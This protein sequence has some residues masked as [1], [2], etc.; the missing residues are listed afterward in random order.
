MGQHTIMTSTCL[1]CLSLTLFTCMMWSIC[2]ARANPIIDIPGDVDL[3]EAMKNIPA[4]SESHADFADPVG[5]FLSA[6]VCTR[7]K[8][9]K[10]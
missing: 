5:D 2:S 9:E 10:G 4:V 3:D 7:G 8:T 1:A 6:G